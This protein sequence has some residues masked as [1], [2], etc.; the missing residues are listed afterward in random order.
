[1]CLEWKLPVLTTDRL[2]LREVTMNDAE[3]MFKYSSNDNV[4]RYLLWETHQTLED[5]KALIEM[6]MESYEM[7]DF[8]H[9]GIE[10]N[11]QLIGTIDY[12]GLNDY[13]GMGEIGYVLSE[14]YWNKG[15]VTEAAKRIIDF[16]FD[17]L[18]LVRIQARCIAE[19]VASSRVMEKCGMKFEGT[20][21]KSLVVKGIYR[22]VN[23]YAIID[24]DR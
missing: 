10:Y 2:I 15:F 13:S 22:D 18:G 16:G 21:R 5:T 23:M 4:S 7:R 8:Y 11:G 12:V 19:N 3:A 17:E 24:D 9:W 6:A 14:D 1:M 20:L